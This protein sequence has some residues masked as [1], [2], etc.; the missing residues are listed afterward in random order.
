MPLLLLLLQHHSPL[1]RWSG[2]KALAEEKAEV[3][4]EA[5]RCAKTGC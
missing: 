3:E 4:V 5:V 1:L 2:E